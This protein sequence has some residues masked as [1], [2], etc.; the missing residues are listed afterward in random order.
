[1]MRPW[2]HIH[3][4]GL[5]GAVAQLSEPLAVLGQGGGVTGDFVFLVHGLTVLSSLFTLS[6]G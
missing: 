4:L 2:E 1:M 3:R 6:I 5:F